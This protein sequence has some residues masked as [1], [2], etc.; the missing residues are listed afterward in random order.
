MVQLQKGAV[1][2]KDFLTYA[3]GVYGADKMIWGSAFGNNEVGLR[4]G[5]AGGA[6]L[7]NAEQYGQLVKMALES[8]EGLTLAQKKAIFYSNAKALFVPGGH[9]AL[10]RRL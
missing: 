3:V 8:A 2:L 5:F 9:A 4:G 1:P 6:A 7:G 10:G